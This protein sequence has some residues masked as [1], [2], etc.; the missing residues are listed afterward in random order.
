MVPAQTAGELPR[1]R[2]ASHQLGTGL[3][4]AHSCQKGVHQPG[5][6][7]GAFFVGQM[8]SAGKELKL[9]PIEALAQV[10]G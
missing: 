6:D 8:T 5:Q 2:F 9:H 3:A 7:F 4:L 10:L 1:A